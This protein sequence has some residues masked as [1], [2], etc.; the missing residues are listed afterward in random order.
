MLVNISSG[1]FKGEKVAGL[2]YRLE[3]NANNRG[4]PMH[5]LSLTAGHK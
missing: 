4:L 1:P 2:A 5:A 3:C